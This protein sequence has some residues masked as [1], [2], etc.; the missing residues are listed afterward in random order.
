MIGRDKTATGDTKEDTFSSSS[1]QPDCRCQQ[2]V[3][4]IRKQTHRHLS[5]GWTSQLHRITMKIVQNLIHL[6]TLIAIA[7]FKLYYIS[8]I[9]R[10]RV[11]GGRWNRRTRVRPKNRHNWVVVRWGQSGGRT[12]QGCGGGGHRGGGHHRCRVLNERE[13]SV[14]GQ[15]SLSCKRETRQI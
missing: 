8:H 14:S 4:F 7:N 11:V 5:A 2:L 15:K 12:R 13:W 1:R 9:A 6:I 10:M 3:E